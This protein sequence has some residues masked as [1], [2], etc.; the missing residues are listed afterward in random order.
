MLFHVLL[1]YLEWWWAEATEMLSSN[2]SWR[3]R[4][5]LPPWLCLAEVRTPK[6][7]LAVCC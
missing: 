2:A 3:G 5:D 1:C 4:C 7:G 6:D